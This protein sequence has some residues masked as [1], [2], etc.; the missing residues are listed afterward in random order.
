M[1]SVSFTHYTLISYRWP[2]VDHSGS[3]SATRRTPRRLTP[4]VP[5][6]S[7]S[8]PNDHFIRLI[9]PEG[10]PG[11]DFKSIS[12]RCNLFEVTFVREMT[13]ETSVLPLGCLQ[14]GIFDQHICHSCL[15]AALRQGG[16][17]NARPCLPHLHRPHCLLRPVLPNPDSPLD[18]SLSLR[19]NL[20]APFSADLS[21]EGRAVGLCWAN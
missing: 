11:A 2:L 17:D 20:L 14:G 12:H 16:S 18:P 1:I 5:R 3:C 21:T 19:R 6:P 7:A 10:N 4:P 8:P 15:A 9:H 13:K